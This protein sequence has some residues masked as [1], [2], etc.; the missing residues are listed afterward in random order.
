[1]LLSGDMLRYTHGSLRQMFTA[2]RSQQLNAIAV[3]YSKIGYNYA[4][5]SMSTLSAWFLNA[6]KRVAQRSQDPLTQSVVDLH[7]GLAYYNLGRLR[8]SKESLEF[9]LETMERQGDSWFRMNCH[10][11]LRHLYAVF[12]H[13]EQEI[14]EANIEQQISETNADPVTNSWAQYGLANAKARLGLLNDAHDHMAR[15]LG[16]IESVESDQLTRAIL[17]NH[18]AFV[19][20]Q[21]S[22]Y[23]GAVSV[24]NESERLIVEK[25]LYVD[26][27]LRTYPMLIEA[28][29]G[30]NWVNLSQNDSIRRAKRLSTRTRLFGWRFPNLRPQVQRVYGR[31]LCTTGRQRKAIRYFEKSIMSARQ[32][33]AEYDEAR[34]LLDLAAVDDERRDKFRAEAVTILKRLK[35]VIP[36][37]EKWQLGEDPDQSCIAPEFEHSS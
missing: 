16:A 34:A 14:A 18:Q 25:F 3:G 15:S 27:T 32:F 20:L 37:A 24:L 8:E 6:A 17:P 19:L 5:F 21:S 30:P 23:S 4:A 29:V 11:H 10:H 9:W 1:M 31:L 2:I 12:G 36:R 28:L 35:A 13:S 22:D 26:Y 33:G 7:I